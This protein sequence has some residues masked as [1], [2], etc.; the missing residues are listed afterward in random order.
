MT[1]G[2]ELERVSS[3]NLGGSRSPHGAPNREVSWSA[4]TTKIYSLF[5]SVT[6]C[7]PT[8]IW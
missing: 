2:Q 5:L 7:T 8:E 1:S 3:Y 6:H 4:I